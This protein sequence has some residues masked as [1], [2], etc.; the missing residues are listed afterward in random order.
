M[1][2]LELFGQS[3]LLAMQAIGGVMATLPIIESHQW[4]A[5]ET[6]A[7]LT[8]IGQASP[9]PNMLLIP[10]IGWKLAGIPGALIA[11]LGFCLPSSI[12]VLM[13]YKRWSTFKQSAWKIAI[14]GALAAIGAGAVLL[15][16][17]AFLRISGL[18]ALGLA[19][20]ALTA[21]LTMKTKIPP[22]VLIA[23]GGIIGATGLPI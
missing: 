14:Q 21:L 9:G 13:M 8:A 7:S 4:M 22:V 17:Y 12:L 15:S 20:M 10:L 3:A 2:L 5:P 6:L 18:S 16:T 19:L 23:A 11:A 1:Q